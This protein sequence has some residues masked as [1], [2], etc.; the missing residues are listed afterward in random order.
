MCRFLE[1]NFKT[2][3]VAPMDE[4]AIIQYITNTFADIHI[5]T[6]QGNS[7]FFYDPGRQLPADH[8]FPFA[9]L[10]T[11][12]SYDQASNLNRPGV[13]RLNIGVSKSTF[14][15]LLTSP[16]SDPG[17]TKTTNTHYDFTALDQLMPHPVYGQMFWLCIL[18]PSKA[19]FEK[20]KTLLAEAYDQDV[21]RHARR[22]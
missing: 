10:V 6:S 1:S 12:D 20:V 4:A 14:Q 2:G 13:F 18:N 22:G 7:F 16:S 17:N 5:E 21:T 11:N 3:I 9:T 8:K 19:T 15:S